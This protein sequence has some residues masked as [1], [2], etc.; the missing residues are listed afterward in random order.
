MSWRTSSTG[1]WAIYN[2]RFCS[3]ELVAGILSLGDD[4]SRF[5]PLDPSPHNEA[6]NRVADDGRYEMRACFAGRCVLCRLEVQ[7]NQVHQLC[8]ISYK[9]PIWAPRRRFQTQSQHRI[10]EWKHYLLQLES[11]SE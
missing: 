6:A 10:G 5:I 7:R 8:I 3:S 9:F 11:P 4:V 1:R 2:G